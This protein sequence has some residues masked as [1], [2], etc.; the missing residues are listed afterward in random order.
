MKSK[1]SKLLNRIKILNINNGALGTIGESD[2]GCLA[3]SWW[4]SGLSH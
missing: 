3:S 1:I 4:C 2:G